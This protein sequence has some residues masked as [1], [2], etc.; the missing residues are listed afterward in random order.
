MRKKNNFEDDRKWH[1]YQFFGSAT[2]TVSKEKVIVHATVANISFSGL[3]LY[4]SN[5]VGKGKKVNIKISFI[6]KA[7]KM[8]DDTIS[9]KVDWQKKFQ[10]MYLTGIIFDD[11]P[12]IVH[13]PRLMEHLS[14][15]IDANKWPQPYKDKRIAIM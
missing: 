3:G 1:R 14:W 10:N 15:L 8:Q 6:D 9:G 11:E 2:V 13:Q 12:N 5:P 4:S 7:G